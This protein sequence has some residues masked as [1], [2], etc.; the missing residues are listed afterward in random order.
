MLRR[1]DL[2]EL[3]ERPLFCHDLRVRSER[4]VDVVGLLFRIRSLVGCEIR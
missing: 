2:E 1:D 4:P 3:C